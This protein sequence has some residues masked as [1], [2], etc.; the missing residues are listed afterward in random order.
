MRLLVVVLALALAGGCASGGDDAGEA[1]GDA[2][3]GAIAGDAAGGETAE[4]A[5]VR[6]TA[7]LVDASRSVIRTAELE[8]RAED[9]PDVSERALGVVEAAGGFLAGQRSELSGEPRAVLTFRVPPEP[10]LDVL[11]DLA[12][13]GDLTS[14]R[15]G[16]DDV[17]GQVVDLEGRLAGTRASVERLRALLADAADVPQVVAVEGELARREA[18]LESLTGQLRALRESVDL[19]TVTL[20]LTPPSAAPAD[21]GDP[22]FADGLRTGGRVLAATAR[23]SATAIGFSLPFL[24][25]AAVV[26][27]PG[28]WAWRRWARPRRPAPAA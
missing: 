23:A 15:V 19:A 11:T 10:F 14:R 17:T 16:S 18:E 1:G 12:E 28:R 8:V 27:L 24:A 5:D 22:T 26:A 25:I 3:R 7:Q 20:T 13:L 6:S 2:A 21:D 9:V 4:T